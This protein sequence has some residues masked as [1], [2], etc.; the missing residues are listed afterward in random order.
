MLESCFKQIETFENKS[1]QTS[2]LHEL[3]HK[4]L[5]SHTE[6]LKHLILGSLHLD[7]TLAFAA[8]KLEETIPTPAPFPT[9]SQIGNIQ[10]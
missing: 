6:Y 1:F 5:F 3:K 4:I 9:S 2:I 10:I 7:L 8:Q